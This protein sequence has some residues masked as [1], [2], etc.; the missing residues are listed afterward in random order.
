MFRFELGLACGVDKGLESTHFTGRVKAGVVSAWIPEGRVR[1]GMGL[2][3][4]IFLGDASGAKRNWR[5]RRPIETTLPLGHGNEGF[6]KV[7]KNGA[8]A[9]GEGG[10]A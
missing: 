2:G 7:S 4:V 5:R 8:P 1:N 6:A 9:S 10:N 3:R